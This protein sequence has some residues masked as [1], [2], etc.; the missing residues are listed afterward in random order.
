M[1]PGYTHTMTYID[2]RIEGDY[3]SVSVKSF[4]TLIGDFTALIC[5]S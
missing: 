3:A 1:V 5:K 4:I 2:S